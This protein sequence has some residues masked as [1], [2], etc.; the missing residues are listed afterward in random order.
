MLETPSAFEESQRKI[1]NQRIRAKLR[2]YADRFLV[3]LVDSENLQ[4][5]NFDNDAFFVR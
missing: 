5:L 4:W 2:P 3:I 1:V